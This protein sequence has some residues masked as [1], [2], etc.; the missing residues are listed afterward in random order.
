MFCAVCKADVDEDVPATWTCDNCS[1][2]P[3]CD[4]HITIHN[5][6]KHVLKPHGGVAKPSALC[7]VHKF[8]LLFYCMSPGC[9]KPICHVRTFT[10]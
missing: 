3:L 7:P 10:L 6:R 8:D 5:T 1:D 9:M 4:A 2:K